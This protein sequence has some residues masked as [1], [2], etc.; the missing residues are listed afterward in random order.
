MRL[1]NFLKTFFSQRCK[2]RIHQDRTKL[3]DRF[4]NF[5]INDDIRNALSSI[6]VEEWKSIDCSEE[7]IEIKSKLLP[8]PEINIEKE[9]VLEEILLKEL[10]A[11]NGI[12]SIDFMNHY[13]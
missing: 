7:N 11:E 9:L 3:L 6:L 4:R 1:C 12:F 10:M 13:L 8:L 5:K 2:E